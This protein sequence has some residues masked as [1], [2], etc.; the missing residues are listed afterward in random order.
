M[1][2]E[3]IMGEVRQPPGSHADC[4]YLLFGNVS[5]TVAGRDRIF[6]SSLIVRGVSYQF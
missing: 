5:S 2:N 6:P 3:L 4:Q 1:I